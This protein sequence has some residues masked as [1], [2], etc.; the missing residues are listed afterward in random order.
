MLLSSHSHRDVESSEGR[1]VEE[2]V[3]EAIRPREKKK[4]VRER[5]KKK[6]KEKGYEISYFDPRRSD[7]APSEA[8]R[9]TNTVSGIIRVTS[10]T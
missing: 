6:K 3:S 10:V 4:K 7:P 8:E 5:K 9:S 2:S 1:A